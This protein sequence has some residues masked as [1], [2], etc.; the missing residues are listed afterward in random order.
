MCG[1][2]CVH[3]R[4]QATIAAMCEVAT[5]EGISEFFVD[6]SQVTPSHAHCG[7]G[8]GLRS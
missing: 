8:F 7:G 6:L 1:L 4:T 5:D 3:G 2:V